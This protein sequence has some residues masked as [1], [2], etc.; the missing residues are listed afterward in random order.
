[1]DVNVLQAHLEISIYHYTDIKL[2]NINDLPENC[3]KIAVCRIFLSL[4][5]KLKLFLTLFRT[6]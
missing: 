1:M 4:Q 6:W 3:L 2:F 5:A